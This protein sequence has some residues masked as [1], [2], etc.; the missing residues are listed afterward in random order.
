MALTT[1][2]FIALFQTLEVPYSTKH[3]QLDAP[4]LISYENNADS[5]VYSG[6][7]AAKSAIEAHIAAMAADVL[8]VLEGLLD[9]WIDLGTDTTRI[10]NG[11]IGNIAGVTDSAVE[12]RAEIQKQVLILV[13]FYRA[14]E[15]YTKLSQ[16]NF[17]RMM[18]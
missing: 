18:R 11:S 4:G 12:E 16:G 7:A 17:I 15:Q 3:N 1:E 13:P 9:A 10:E 2:R 5:Q 8:T 6:T 14:H